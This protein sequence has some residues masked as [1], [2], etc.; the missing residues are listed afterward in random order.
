MRQNLILKRRRLGGFDLWCIS[1]SSWRKE[2]HKSKRYREFEIWERRESTQHTPRRARKRRP[3]FEFQ[4]I[5]RRRCIRLWRLSNRSD[6]V[7][8]H[9]RDRRSRRLYPRNPIKRLFLTSLTVC[10]HPNRCAVE[11]PGSRRWTE[12]DHVGFSG[13]NRS[14]AISATP[15]LRRT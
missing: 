6:A 11:F 1:I 13:S 2:A 8:W 4:W 3:I 15:Q 9:R 7:R 12:E 5:S 10:I 14:V